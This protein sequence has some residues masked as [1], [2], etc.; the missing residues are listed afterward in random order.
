MKKIFT[1]SLIVFFAL[2]INAQDVIKLVGNTQLKAKVLEVKENTI[3]Y[4]RF[5]NIGG[6]IYTIGKNKINQ[7][8]Y[9]NGIVENYANTT[10]IRQM[11]NRT[12]KVKG[13]DYEKFLENTNL[14]VALNKPT[15][16]TYTG[17]EFENEKQRMYKEKLVQT[18][19]DTSLYKYAL[20]K[21]PNVF[22]YAESNKK[23][24]LVD[25][26]KSKP[27]LNNKPTLIITW[28]WRWCWPCVK[29][30]DTLLENYDKNKYNLIIINKIEKSNAN[31]AAV[32]NKVKTDLKN[33]SR[34]YFLKKATALYDIENNLE[35]Y[36]KNTAP[37]LIW[38]DKDLN[39]RSTFNG[40]AIN[41][42]QIMNVF[43]FTPNSYY[44]NNFYSDFTNG[45]PANANEAEYRIIRERI[46]NIIKVT[47]VA[48]KKLSGLQNRTNFFVEDEFNNVEPLK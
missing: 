17:A 19:P 40:F 37:L 45:F 36:D 26:I 39:V 7:I 15:F 23:V 42:Q 16:I 4:K 5:D 31:I 41:Y 11:E 44:N 43:N 34:S 47:T 1:L 27:A 8:I 18:M 33:N 48:N 25:F 32:I 14:N 9:Q 24:R 10:G 2:S 3:T 35:R 13:I 38:A 28:A 46:G 22:M 12:T 6:P 29:M 30:I 20:M 21:L